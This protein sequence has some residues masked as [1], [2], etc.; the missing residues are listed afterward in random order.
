MTVLVTQARW[1]ERRSLIYF[2]HKDLL[3]NYYIQGVMLDS[4]KVPWF[5]CSIIGKEPTVQDKTRVHKTETALPRHTFQFR[6]FKLKKVNQDLE[7]ESCILSLWI[8][9]FVYIFL[10]CNLVSWIQVANAWS[11][12]PHL[13]VA[14]RTTAVVSWAYPVE[15][16]SWPQN[17]FESLAHW[18]GTF[19]WHWLFFSYRRQREIFLGEF[20]KGLGVFWF[21][22]VFVIFWVM[23]SVTS[24]L[25]EIILCILCRR[26]VLSYYILMMRSN[27]LGQR[28]HSNI[29]EDILY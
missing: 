25:K 14:G 4:L 2:F 12:L 29:E 24:L 28:K 15:E 3:N 17:V 13:P 19:H 9:F 16:S 21:C 20:P 22:F 18:T 6:I 7:G 26:A 11:F 23:C 1:I 8:A 5:L 27:Y 10:K